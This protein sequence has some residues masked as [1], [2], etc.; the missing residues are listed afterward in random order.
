[1]CLLGDFFRRSD[2]LRFSGGSVN[3]HDVFPLLADLALFIDKLEKAQN[4][5]VAESKV[6]E[7]A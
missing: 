6:K 5:P 3:S 2:E 1:V 7:D 4:A